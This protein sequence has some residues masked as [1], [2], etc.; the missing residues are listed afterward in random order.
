MRWR[1]PFRRLRPGRKTRRVLGL[2]LIV[3]LATYSYVY[4]QVERSQSPT[5]RYMTLEDGRQLAYLAINAQPSPRHRVVLIHGAPTHA[6]SWLTFIRRCAWTFSD[7]E[8]IIVDRLGY[9]NSD[10]ASEPSLEAQ[11]RSLEAFLQP[12]VI[13]VGHSYGGPVALRAA[14]DYP[15]LVGGVVLAA[16]ACDAN[17]NDSQTLRWLLDQVPIVMPQTWATSNRE[18]LSLTDE[19]RSMQPLLDRVRCPV[20][21]VHGT[22]DPVCPHDG[23][24]RYLQEQ[25]VNAAGF[26]L[27][28]LPRAGHNVHLNYPQEIAAEL[29]AMLTAAGSRATN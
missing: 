22:W 27:V 23:T 14:A 21:M 18:L 3:A 4:V 2:L 28:T 1:L 19:N 13:L 11:A 16:G 12:G 5:D 7:V 20:A 15:D 9:G 6:G 26:D 8:F 10:R 24:A 25:L 17:M 29:H